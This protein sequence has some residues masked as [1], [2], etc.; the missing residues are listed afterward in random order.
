MW[1]CK[2]CGHLFEKPKRWE[3]THGLDFPP[4]ETMYGCPKCLGDYAEALQCDG[5]D[6]YILDTYIKTVDNKRYCSECY[7]EHDLG[8]ED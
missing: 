3:E 7:Q 5:C 6:E 2:K 8:D 4:Y 1:V